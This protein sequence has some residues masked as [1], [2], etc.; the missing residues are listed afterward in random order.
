MRK[1]VKNKLRANIRFDN[2]AQMRTVNFAVAP[3]V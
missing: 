3:T 1:F 2:V